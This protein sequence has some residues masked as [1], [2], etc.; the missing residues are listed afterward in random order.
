MSKLD[1]DSSSIN[2][3]LCD[4]KARMK[5]IFCICPVERVLLLI[6]LSKS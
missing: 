1:M 6:G 5:D 3:S 4:A 2:I